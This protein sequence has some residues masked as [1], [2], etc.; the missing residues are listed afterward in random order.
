V[1]P[2]QLDPRCGEQSPQVVVGVAVGEI[3]G[4]GQRSVGR[5]LADA[6]QASDHDVWPSDGHRL[7][8]RDPIRADH[9]PSSNRSYPLFT[10]EEAGAARAAQLSWAQPGEG[11]LVP[12][13][14]S[15]LSHPHAWAVATAAGRDDTPSF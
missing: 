14:S 3:E 6:H 1:A 9:S 10:G 15:G 12:S 13:E 5:R 7:F 8:V 2:S 11:Q 4:L